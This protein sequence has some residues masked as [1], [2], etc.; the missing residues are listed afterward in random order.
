VRFARTRVAHEHDRLGTL[1]VAAFRELTHL[2]RRD[3]RRLAE[4]ELVQ[5][6][7]ARQMRLFDAPVDSAPLAILQLGGQQGLE[8][9]QVRL[10]LAFG[11]LGQRRALARHRRYM[12][13]DALLLDD[14]LAHTRLVLDTRAHRAP[15]PT[16][17]SS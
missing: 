9:G 16:S 15:R 14:A 12:Q 7:D 17:R 5:R 3:R 4:V 8:V 10:P 1:Q 13:H 6:L 11:L 2:R